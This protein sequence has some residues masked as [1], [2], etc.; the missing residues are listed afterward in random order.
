MSLSR[1][2]SFLLQ[3]ACLLVVALYAWMID[4]KGITTDEGFRLWIING[5][6]PANPAGPAATAMWANVIAANAPF[7]YQPLYFLIQNSLMRL[8]HTQSLLFFRSV[9]LVFLWI[10]LQGL[11]ALSRDWRPAARLFLLGIFSLNAFLFMH[12][13][14]IREYIAG[15]AFYIWTSWLVL[16][17]DA[18]RLERPWADTAWFAGY[19]VALV[20]GFYLQSWTVFPAAAQGL[21][22]I[23]R[24]PGDRLRHFA[25]LALSYVIAVTAIWPYLENNQQKINIGLWATEPE[26]LGQHLFAGF[27]LVLSGHLPGVSRVA[28]GL[29]WFWFAALVAGVICFFS[30]RTNYASPLP[31]REM[32]RQGLLLLLCVLV[33]VAFQI[34][35]ALKVEKLSLWPR[36]FIIHYFFLMWLAALLFHRLLDWRAATVAGRNSGRVAHAGAV[37]LAAVVIGAGVFQVGSFRRDPMLDTS[38]SLASNWRVWAAQLNQVLRPAD[39]VVMP[40]FISRATLTFNQPMARPVLLISDL[41]AA[42]LTATPR[43]VY[44]ESSEIQADRDELRAK[45]AAAGFTSVEERPMFAADGRTVLPDRKLVIF[46]RN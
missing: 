3:F 45:A 38:Q 20:I 16:R 27:H 36:Y 34:A 35:Y 6:Q 39:A 14:Q 41:P 26:S 21:F 4:L 10:A 8:F 28:D 12:V 32:Q 22:L 18:R 31:R 24:R 2:S 44:L 11:L 17:L 1:K 23:L 5:G 40:D 33:S 13:L 29:F 42:N 25:H 9:N 30:N 37:A 7:A 43:L 19:G 15:V 46:T